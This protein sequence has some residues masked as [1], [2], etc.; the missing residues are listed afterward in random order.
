MDIQIEVSILQRLHELWGRDAHEFNPQRFENGILSACKVPQAYTP[1]GLGIR[2][3][4]GNHFAMIELKDH[5]S[6]T[7]QVF[8]LT[9]PDIPTLLSELL[10]SSNK[11]G[12]LLQNHLYN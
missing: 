6:P 4:V 2:V 1:F 7:I 10:H 9:H 3:C 11:Y 12:L 5:V 8:I